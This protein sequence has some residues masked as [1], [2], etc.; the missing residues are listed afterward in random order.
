MRESYAGK[1]EADIAVRRAFMLR[2]QGV[3][4]TELLAEIREKNHE[5]IT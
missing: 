3:C 2:Y 5:N 1:K 4:L